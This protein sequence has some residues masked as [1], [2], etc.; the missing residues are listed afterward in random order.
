MAV[1]NRSM[2]Q[3]ETV[4]PESYLERTSQFTGLSWNVRGDVLRYDAG[5]GEK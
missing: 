3:R 2:G 1:I 5:D 4:E